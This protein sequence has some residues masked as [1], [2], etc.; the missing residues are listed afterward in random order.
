[1]ILGIIVFAL[2]ILG[3][4]DFFNDCS[5]FLYVA[6][7]AI[8]IEYFVGFV[9]GECKSL[10]PF[11]GT[12]FATFVLFYFNVPLINA[13]AICMCFENVIFFIAGCFLIKII[14]KRIIENENIEIKLK[15]EEDFDDDD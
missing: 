10:F 12:L 13:F 14:N 5:F 2:S 9:T 3:I 1:M 11:W 4:Y 6:L 8:I 15:K 7:S